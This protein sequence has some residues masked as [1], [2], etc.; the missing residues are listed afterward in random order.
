MTS[1]DLSEIDETRSVPKLKGIIVNDET[2][3]KKIK[4]G[5]FLPVS[6]SDS[7]RWLGNEHVRFSFEKFDTR[8]RSGPL[9]NGRTPVFIGRSRLPFRSRERVNGFHFGV[10]SLE[11]R[12]RLSSRPYVT[13][14]KRTFIR[15]PRQNRVS[16]YRL[17]SRRESISNR[18]RPGSPLL[19]RHESDKKGQCAKTKDRGEAGPQEDSPSRK[20]ENGPKASGLSDSVSLFLSL[21]LSLGTSTPR[22]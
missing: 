6:L 22:W 9:F 11:I 7:A 20:V 1:T 13:R 16:P 10:T 19:T 4:N 2:K 3:N 21:S 5:R 18:P 17:L 14:D 15:P 8:V 12:S